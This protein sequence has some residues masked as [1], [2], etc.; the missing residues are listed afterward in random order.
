M[1]VSSIWVFYRGI[2]YMEI[3][4]HLCGIYPTTW[5]T[6]T[7]DCQICQITCGDVFPAS[8]QIWTYTPQDIQLQRS[9]AN[10]LTTASLCISLVPHSRET[11]GEGT[12]RNSFLKSVGDYWVWYLRQ[13]EAGLSS[14]LLRSSCSLAVLTGFSTCGSVSP[15]N[16]DLDLAT[17]EESP[18]HALRSACFSRCWE[19]L[20][21]SCVFYG[22]G[23]CPA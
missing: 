12:E 20:Y 21:I 13:Q 1:F 5:G 8:G 10:C 2:I 19:K 16:R 14:P 11:E 22:T 9:S 7:K 3:N 17:R 18:G 23:N 15:F 6:A 4:L